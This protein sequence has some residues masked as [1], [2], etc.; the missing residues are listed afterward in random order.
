MSF[1]TEKELL[2]VVLCNT[3]FQEFLNSNPN[4]TYYKIEPKG[5]FGVPDLIFGKIKPFVS[6]NKSRFRTIA[7]EMKLCQWKRA[8]AQAFR[9]RAFANLSFVILD[10][11]R[12]NPA[13]ANIDK[14][15]RANI[16]LISVD[17]V[18]KHTIHHMPRYKKPFSTQF[19]SVLSHILLDKCFNQET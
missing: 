2:K 12:I 18:G 10:N 14:F 19:E 17:F 8:L 4:C 6:N 9:Y 5:L 11:S 7:C 15:R 3:V 1:K 16:G 13:L